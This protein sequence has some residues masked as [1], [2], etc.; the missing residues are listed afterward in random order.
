MD[1][2][3]VM[4]DD[5]NN[6]VIVSPEDYDED[7]RFKAYGMKR[8]KVVMS[9]KNFNAVMQQA[10]IRKKRMEKINVNPHIRRRKKR[11][12][13]LEDDFI[14][15]AEHITYEYYDDPNEICDRLRLL[16]SSKASGD[17]NHNQEINSILEELRE[18]GYI[19]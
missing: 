19:A 15:Y 16:I 18:G 9:K 3:E 5:N 11:G 14:P 10:N 8:R 2:A 12:A 17:T 4:K 1:P 13:G 7:G 6:V